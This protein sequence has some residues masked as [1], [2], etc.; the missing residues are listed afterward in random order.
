MQKITPCLWFNTE[1]EQAVKFY[2]SIFKN[3]GIDSL[4]R[5]LE[6]EPRPEG[7]IRTIVF[8][9][10]DQEFMALNGGPEYK[11]TPAISFYVRC[12][13][14]KEIDDLWQKLSEGG[15]VLMEYKKYPF[16]EKYGWLEDKFGLSWQLNLNESGQKISPLL[17]FA[18][19][20]HGKSEEA[21]NYYISQFK[22]SKVIDIVYSDNK[23]ELE[24]KR[25]IHSRF[26][27]DGQE[28]LAM[29]G[30]EDQP[31]EFTP[32]ISFIINCKTQ[33]E[34]DK[35]WKNLSEEGEEVQC[36]WLTDKYGIHLTA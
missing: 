26:L 29:D 12:K 5:S 13:T 10:E 9:L 6:G 7:M 36:G 34:V 27:L 31:H 15:K 32:G 14:L 28:F 22:N 23:E 2:T 20:T 19:N 25:V 11:F 18:G 21:I 24:G 1:S 33:K 4:T 16:S 8:H 30:G 3:S 35:F 17:M